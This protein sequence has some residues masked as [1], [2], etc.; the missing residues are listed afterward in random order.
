MTIDE[1]KTIGVV[2]A[3]Q[4]GRGIAQVLATAGWH[5]RL[6][7]VTDQAL[8]GAITKIRQGIMKAIEKG[9]LRRDQSGAVMDF[10]QP[11]SRIE[12]LHDAQMV[13]EA[14]PEDRVMKRGLFAQLGKICEPSTV[15]A[16]NTSSVSIATL[17][18]ASGRADRVVGIHFMNPVPLMRLVE[19]VRAVET[20]EG[21]MQL[22]LALVRR[23]GKTAV[24]SKDVPGFIVNRVLMPMINEAVFA[25]DE[26][27]ASA[28]AIDLAMVE[29]TNQ[30]VGPLA[31]ADRIGL[32]TVL[33]I[34]EVLHQDLGDPKFR[35][36][37]LLQKYVDAGRLGKKSGRGFY[38]YNEQPVAM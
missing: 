34:C 1:I 21:T 33:A 12:Q 10:I 14:I 35:P 9:A 3:G 32:D 18:M 37:P 11:T 31:L 29:G 8:D 15:L 4:M 28:E 26:G 38:L 23:L 25:L 30:P 20:S 7:D 17:G 5:V 36:C 27:V 19:V 6:V 13:I 22:A 16:S 2:G 24:V